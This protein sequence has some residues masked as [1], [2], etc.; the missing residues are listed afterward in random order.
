[1]ARTRLAKLSPLDGSPDTTWNPG[2]NG[3]AFAL[4]RQPDGTIVTG[5][6]F[7]QVAGTPRRLLAALPPVADAVFADG[8]E[9]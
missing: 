2:A 1:V 5:G 7:T 8:F 6:L 9:E 4:A 3:I